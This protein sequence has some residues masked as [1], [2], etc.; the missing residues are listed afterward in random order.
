MQDGKDID[1]SNGGENENCVTEAVDVENIALVVSFSFQIAFVTSKKSLEVAVL[2]R[3]IVRQSVT[4]FNIYF[5]LWTKIIFKKL[6][7]RL[8]LCSVSCC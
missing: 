5:A 8:N 4:F 1:I 7:L 6:Y 3:G 2:I